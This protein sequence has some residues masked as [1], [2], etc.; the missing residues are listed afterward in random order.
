[1]NDAY[2]KRKFG[3][4][5]GEVM[6]LFDRYNFRCAFCLRPEGGRR[7][8]LD[9][10]HAFDRVKIK[11]VKQGLT[12]WI[13]ETVG[14]NGISYAYEHSDKKKARQGLKRMLRRDSV[15][16]PLCLRCNK[17]LALLEDSKAPC[18]TIERLENA[19]RCLKEYERKTLTKTESTDTI[20]RC[21]R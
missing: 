19:I 21:V 8:A 7:L 3:W 1:M 14:P 15:R 11:V 10:W 6:A 20:P 9:H 18:S 2:Y 17:A 12:S 5:L 16:Q 13:A 4:S